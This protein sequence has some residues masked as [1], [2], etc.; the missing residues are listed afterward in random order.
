MVQAVRQGKICE[1]RERG[2]AGGDNPILNLSGLRLET[3]NV[4][5]GS[6]FAVCIW[7]MSVR[8]GGERAGRY[9]VSK[10][11]VWFENPI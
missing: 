9:M 7:S 5:L 4:D 2:G 6:F 10:H 3:Q 8:T 1:K 11:Y